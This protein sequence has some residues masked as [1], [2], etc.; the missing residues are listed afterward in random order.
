MLLIS[1]IYIFLQATNYGGFKCANACA[2][3]TIRSPTTSGRRWTGEILRLLA[4]NSKNYADFFSD[5]NTMWKMSLLIF[6]VKKLRPL[7]VPHH[8]STFGAPPFVHFRCPAIHPLS[9]PHL[10]STF[11]APPFW[12]KVLSAA[13]FI[14][15]L[16]RPISFG[17]KNSALRPFD[18]N[19]KMSISIKC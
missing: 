16:F 4:N 10:T 6:C 18:W 17:A 15:D 9:V 12:P 13:D 2:V 1:V 7:S 3:S 14:Q 11:G 19:F 5:Y 8:S